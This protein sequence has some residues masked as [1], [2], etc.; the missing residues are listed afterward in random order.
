MDFNNSLTKTNLMKAFAGESQAGNR[1]AFSAAQAGKDGYRQISD[2]FIE[3]AQNEKEHAE[4]FYKLLLNKNGTCSCPQIT[5]TADFPAVLSTTLENLSAAAATEHDEAYSIYPNFAQ[6]ANEEGFSDI[7]QVFIE[8]AEVESAHEARFL[9]LAD[10]VRL[11]RVFK[12]D[13][14][15][16]WKCNNCGY[17][18]TGMDAPGICPACKHTIDYYELFVENY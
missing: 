7:A 3:T 4:I 6:T 11:G 15:V 14:E 13:N 16:K 18:H 8:I 2:I 12:K 9:K 10:N 1:Y 5:I 17:I